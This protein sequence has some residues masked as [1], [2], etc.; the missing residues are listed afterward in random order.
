MSKNQNQSHPSHQS[1]QRFI[2]SV[3]NK[4]SKW[5]QANCLKRVWLVEKVA[6]FFWTN[7]RAKFSKTEAIPD[8]HSNLLWN[9]SII[10]SKFLRMMVDK[11]L[12]LC[13]WSHCDLIVC[14]SDLCSHKHSL[15]SSENRPH[16][17]YYWRS[18]HNC[19]DCFHIRFLNR[20]SHMWFPY[21]YS[22]LLI[23]CVVTRHVSTLEL[24]KA[25]FM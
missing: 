21:I 24:L 23:V 3:A 13:E 7:H 11:G 22:H 20:G 8:R 2:F 16:F 4:K 12:T 9:N 14:G 19:K 25:I 17:H 18:V 15:R 6:R 1:E 5:K 10:R